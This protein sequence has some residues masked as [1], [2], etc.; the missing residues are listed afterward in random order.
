MGSDWPLPSK[1]DMG[2]RMPNCLRTAMK[3]MMTTPMAHSSMPW[4]PMASVR[5]SPLGAQPEHKALT[6]RGSGR[7]NKQGPMV[8]TEVTWEMAGLGLDVQRLHVFVSRP[9]PLR[10]H[11]NRASRLDEG[12]LNVNT[13]AEVENMWRP[14]YMENLPLRTHERKRGLCH[15]S[16]ITVH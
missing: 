7:V 11:E 9:R 2:S 16:F 10:K 8:L 1:E 3:R 6:L 13:D 15:Q 14:T 5:G 4:S 12:R